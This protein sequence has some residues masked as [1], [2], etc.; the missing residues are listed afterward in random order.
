MRILAD[1]RGGVSLAQLPIYLK[2]NLPF[3]LDLNELGYAKLKDL[4]VSMPND[5]KI[6]LRGHNHPFAFLA[7]YL[8]KKPQSQDFQNKT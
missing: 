4:I 1:Y 2:R 3:A 6:E 8:K 7:K 5:I